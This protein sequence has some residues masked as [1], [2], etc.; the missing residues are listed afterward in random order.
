MV[1]NEGA[2]EILALADALRV[3]LLRLHA[4]SQTTSSPHQ[5][6]IVTEHALRDIDAFMAMYVQ[7]RDAQVPLAPMSLGVLLRDTQTS[8]GQY[9][10]LTATELVVD[11]HAS[12]QL[13]LGDVRTLRIGLELVVKTLCDFASDA[14]H[15]QVVIR[16]DTR[17]GYPRLGAYRRDID[18]NARDVAL[19]RKLIGGAQ[20]NAGVFHQLGALR[21]AVATKLLEPIGL[22]LRSAK[23][24][25]Q[26]GLALQLQPSDQVSLFGA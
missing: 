24:S 20:I 8:L 3:P 13:V 23:S 17:H 11:D 18:I 12:H 6:R 9:A 2:S 25:G 5:S 22:T 4:A 14:P 10:S 1:M 21:I 16:A 19:A 15:P 26:R 7:H